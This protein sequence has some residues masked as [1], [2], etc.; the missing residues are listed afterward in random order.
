[1]SGSVVARVAGQ[2][3]GLTDL[4]AREAELARGPRARHL[5]PGDGPARAY[6]RRWLVRE[7][8]TEAVLRHELG[9]DDGA[10]GPL[11]AHVTAA[12]AVSEDEARDYYV[13][14][15]DLFRRPERRRIRHAVFPE[16][17]A[18]R[19]LAVAAVGGPASGDDV[20]IG[21]GELAGPLEDALFAARVGDIVG[22]IR[23]EHG[24][25]VARIEGVEP[26]SRSAFDEVRVGIE[27][28]LLAAARRRAFEDWLERRRS[29]LAVVMPEFEHPGNPAVGLPTH[30][31]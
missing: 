5:P 2:A 7:L 27:A 19:A 26:A 16:E 9:A 1:M 23:T 15:P 29:E 3:I 17:A 13:R 10:L 14:N 28:E 8:V 31:H 24:W 6:A 12:A 25:H 22:P 20:T 21:R 18:A 4:E 30:R 11:V